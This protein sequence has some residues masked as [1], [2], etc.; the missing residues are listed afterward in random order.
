VHAPQSPPPLA[1]SAQRV[2]NGMIYPAPVHRLC[3]FSPRGALGRTP[4]QAP[5]CERSTRWRYSR[6][7]R[8]LAPGGRALHRLGLG[9]GKARGNACIGAAALHLCTSLRPLRSG[10]S[11]AP[12]CEFLCGCRGSLLAGHPS[13]VRQ[14]ASSRPRLCSGLIYRGGA[15]Q[16]G[17]ERCWGEISTNTGRERAPEGRHGLYV[18][19][20]AQQHPHR[21]HPT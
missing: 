6:Q 10:G 19:D 16:T 3:R 12:L 7:R 11:V 13:S 21:L 18:A 4:R 5:G 2:V 14:A 1:C 20:T 17:R 15:P 9:Y 8:L